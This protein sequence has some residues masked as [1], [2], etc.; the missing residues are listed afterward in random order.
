[1]YLTDVVSEMVMHI[2]VDTGTMHNVIDI[3]IARLISL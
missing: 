3:N 2:L 1:M